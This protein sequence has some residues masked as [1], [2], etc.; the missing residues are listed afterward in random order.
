MH[1]VCFLIFLALSII[2]SIVVAIFKRP[3]MLNSLNGPTNQVVLA[4][5]L[6]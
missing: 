6:F 1:P 5:D 4:I 2:S 3:L